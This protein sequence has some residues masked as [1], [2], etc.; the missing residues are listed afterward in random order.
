MDSTATEASV[1]DSEFG[2]DFTSSEVKTSAEMKTLYESMPQ[3]DT[4]QVQFESQVE[5]VCAKKGCWMKL[6]LT[7]EQ[8]AHVTF[9]DYGFFVPKDSQGQRMLVN[10]VAFIEQTDVETLRHYAE[11]AGK[12]EAEIANITEPELNYRFIATGV[13]V[14]E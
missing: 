6:E 1:S 7:E 14:V 9:K 12:S 3:G 8:N 5:S 4:L 2:E 10:G 11:D 13:K